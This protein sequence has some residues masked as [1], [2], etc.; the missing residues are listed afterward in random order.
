MITKAKETFGRIDILV[1]NA[2]WTCTGLALDDTEKDYD[3]TLDTTVKGV[4]FACQAAAQVMIPQG[5]G[6]IINI[7]SNFAIS[8][9]GEPAPF[10]ARPRLP[11]T[12]CR[13]PFHWSGPSRVW[14]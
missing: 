8:A 7:G 6:R 5:G 11:C 4:F 3:G 1:N 13:G 14:W 9:L 10:T 12:S 2:S